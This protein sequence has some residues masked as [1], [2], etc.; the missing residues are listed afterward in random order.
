M[1]SCRS[2]VQYLGRVYR[3]GTLDIHNILSNY[4]QLTRNN[5]FAILDGGNFQTDGGLINISV[6]GI[7]AYN[8][9]TGVITLRGY[10]NTSSGNMS[11]YQ[12][13]YYTSEREPNT[14]LYLAKVRFGFSL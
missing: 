10:S 9:T 5:F 4:A 14:P 2:E 8:S 7:S 6:G 1:F 13:V 11:L 12:K 3:N